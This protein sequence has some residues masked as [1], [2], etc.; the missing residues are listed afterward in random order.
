MFESSHVCLLNKT[1]LLP[2][3]DFDPAL[4]KTYV[5]QVNPSLRI[6]SLSA[7]TGEGFEEWIDWVRKVMSNE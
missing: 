5:H 3:V 1:D 2:Y 6:I 4:F 7:R